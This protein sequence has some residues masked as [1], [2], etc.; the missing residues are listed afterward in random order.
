MISLR[1]VRYFIATAESG[2]VSA[3]ARLLRVS[4]SAVTLA[5]RELERDLGVTLLDR[6]ANGVSLTREGLQFLYHARNIQAS[7]SDALQSMR[8]DT[9]ETR[10]ELSIGVSYTVSG[11][12]LFPLLARFRRSFPEI[13][14]RVEEGGSRDIEAK[15]V[16]GELDCAV[17]LASSEDDANTFTFKPLLRAQRRLWLCGGHRLLAHDRVPLEE[18]AGEPYVMLATDVVEQVTLAYW[19]KEGLAPRVVFRTYSLEAVRSM[20]ATGAAVTILADISYRPWSLDGSRVE[21]RRLACSIPPM[22]IGLIAVRGRTLS[23]PCRLFRRFMIDAS[24]NG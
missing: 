21:A 3:A 16:S 19:R 20:V 23:T 6:R 22:I 10:G 24:K 1:Q 8:Q 9:L 11:Y 14:V 17:M 13:S 7:V 15:L 5:V 18:V 2:Q 4:Q 12:F